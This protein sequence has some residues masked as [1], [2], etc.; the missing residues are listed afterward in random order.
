MNFYEQLFNKGKSSGEGMTH[1][2][3]LFALKI[4]SGKIEELEGVP[5]LTF[6]ANGQPLLDYLISGNTVQN[7]TPT[8]V[9]PIMPEGTG[10]K[11]ANLFDITAATSGKYVRDTD[12]SIRNSND[13][14]ASDYIDVSNI[15]TLYP[16][17]FTSASPVKQWAAFYDSNKT[18]VSGFSG[19]NQAIT[20]PNNAVYV[21]LTVDNNY[22]NVFTV[23]KNQLSVYEPYGQF[24][25]PISSAGQTTPVYLGQVQT[26]RKIKKYECTGEENWQIY[27]DSGGTY[28]VWQF[29][30]NN[31]TNGIALSSALSNIAGYGVTA[32]NR[33]SYPYGVFLVTS[34]TGIAFQMVGAK[35]TFPNVTAWKTYLQQQYASGTPVCVWY[36]LAN[37]TTG[38]VNEPLMKIGDYADTVSKAQ[39][40]VEIPTIKGSNSLA[41]DTTVQ[42]SNVYI[43]YKK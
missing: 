25:I 23:S 38:I 37:E 16:Q 36:V 39:A 13:S 8:P 3:R 11:T 35:D 9:N 42:P 2:E 15:T 41:V 5:P 26:T 14:Y 33:N 29:Y 1:F 17:Y 6:K 31:T 18:F 27:S 10:N 21:R 28:G 12:G 30:A 20:V 22:I 4:G 43:K 19:Y 40:G 34:G 24:K 32:L 7:D